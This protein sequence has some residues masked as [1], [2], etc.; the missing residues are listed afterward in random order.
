MTTCNVNA[1]VLRHTDVRKPNIVVGKNALVTDKADIAF[2]GKSRLEY[3]KIFNE[4]VLHILE[5][6]ACPEDSSNPG[7]PDLDA[8]YAEL[9]ERPV[10]GQFWF[11]STQDR[12]FFWDDTRWVP[13]SRLDDIAGNSGIIA[14]GETIPLPI[15]QTTGL[16]FDMSECVF[17]VSPFNMDEEIE[18]LVCTVDTSGIVLSQY[19]PLYSSDVVDGCA[20]YIVVGIRNNNNLGSY[21]CLPASLPSITPTPT[22]SISVTPSITPSEGIIPSVTPS[23][24][25][26]IELSPSATPS[27]TPSTSTGFIPPTPSVTPT[28]SITPTPSRSFGAPAPSPSVTPTRTPSVTITPTRTPSVTVTP[29]IT[30][31]PSPTVT[32]SITVSRTPT[33]TVT[34]SITRTPSITPTPSRSPIAPLGL[35]VDVINEDGYCQTNPSGCSGWRRFFSASITGS[36]TGGVAPYTVTSHTVTTGPL[37]S[38]TSSSANV[39]GPTIAGAFGGRTTACNPGICPGSGSVEVPITVTVN[40]Q[41]SLG[42]TASD[43]V[44]T[45][46]LI[47]DGSPS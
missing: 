42:N 38:I 12:I 2:P 17:F 44:S 22:N 11:N 6:F 25:P 28:I 23:V 32:P 26:S 8:A 43:S 29:S 47:F 31:T 13:L 3:G 21:Q 18:Y 35:T 41:D 30:R 39:V 36:I 15:S 14:H 10:H 9:L 24:T 5:N 34:P 37:Y 45:T 1:Y 7:N 33:P 20:N 4:N 16:P 19:R 46:I 27:I 40:I